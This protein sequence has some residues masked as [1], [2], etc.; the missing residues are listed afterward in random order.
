MRSS[1]EF[2]YRLSCSTQVRT[3]R[4][5][6]ALSLLNVSVFFSFSFYLALLWRVNA[7]GKLRP[8]GRFKFRRSTRAPFLSFSFTS[9]LLFPSF[10]PFLPSRFAPAFL[11][12]D[13]VSTWVPTYYLLKNYSSAELRFNLNYM[14]IIVKRSMYNQIVRNLLLYPIYMHM[15]YGWSRSEKDDVRKRATKMKAKLCEPTTYSNMKF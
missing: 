11:R 7:R 4:D 10:L 9:F 6:R 3:P 14:R 15:Y 2:S 13:D 12:Q 5:I 8:S 1:F